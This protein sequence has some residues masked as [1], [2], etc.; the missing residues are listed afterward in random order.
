MALVLVSMGLSLLAASSAHSQ[1]YPSKPI[2][3]IGGSAGGGNDNVAR[4]I[5][6]G[7]SAPLGQP[8]IV[9]NRSGGSVVS[10]EAGAKAPPDG[11]TL[12]VIGSAL[13]VVPMLEKAPYD[14]ITDFAPVTLVTRVVSVVAVHPSLP[15]KSVKELIALAKAH[16]DQ[17]NFASGS[18]GG[19][20]QLATELFKSMSGT[21]FLAV[22]YK[23]GP[24]AVTAILSGEVQAMIN[25]LGLVGPHVKSGKLRGLAVTSATP[26]LS[27]P[28]LPT[29]A[30][31]GLPGYEWIGV[32]GL[33]AP[34]KTPAAIV[35][36]LNREV[37]RVLT[38]SEV[39]ERFLTGGEEV[40][41]N[42]PEQFA[43]VIKIEMTKV[44]KILKD[45]GTRPK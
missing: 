13:W 29:V 26:S 6:Q 24:P 11:Y 34:S 9:E 36:R 19:S 44:A 14:V 39:K 30:E 38:A 16:P 27:A 21:R 10:A 43:A 20:Q 40:V 15:V 42:S 45:A 37:V 32:S 35:A 23:G 1:D 25:D 2:R 3:I 4:I 28:G 17:L 22:P 18:L 31:S 41:A 8:V 33:Y 12:L 7:I 5:A